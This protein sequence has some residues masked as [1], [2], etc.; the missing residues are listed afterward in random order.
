MVQT[1]RRI[2][3]IKQRCYIYDIVLYIKI[4]HK[5]SPYHNDFCFQSQQ[6]SISIEVVWKTFHQIR[7][8]EL[9]SVRWILYCPPLG[10]LGHLN[11]G[12]GGGTQRDRILEYFPNPPIFTLQQ[13]L[14]I[15]RGGLNRWGPSMICTITNVPINRNYCKRFLFYSTMVFFTAVAV[16][17]NY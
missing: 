2:S 8:W 9:Q 16:L 1:L 17:H 14:A 5:P 15:K 4:V 10:T 6:Y 3:A 12:G 7:I 13:F 11:K